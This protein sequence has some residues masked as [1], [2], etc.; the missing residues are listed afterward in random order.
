EVLLHQ[1][2]GCV[3]QSVTCHRS[4]RLPPSELWHAGVAEHERPRR[5]GYSICRAHD[6]IHHTDSN[7]WHHTLTQCAAAR[8]CCNRCA[9]WPPSLSLGLG[10]HEFRGKTIV[11]VVWCGS[12]CSL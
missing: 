2:Q 10:I 8:C 3:C 6:R 12:H 1:L 4:L 7:K 5:K 9:S 11:V